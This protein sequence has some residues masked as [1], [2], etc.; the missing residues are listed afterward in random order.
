MKGA[1]RCRRVPM[2]ATLRPG[3]DAAEPTTQKR[4]RLKINP[5]NIRHCV[6][7]MIAGPRNHL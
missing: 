4:L 5:E 6:A 7:F 1:T 3:C 2:L